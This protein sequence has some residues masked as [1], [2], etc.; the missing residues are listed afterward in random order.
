MEATRKR[1]GGPWATRQAFW[2]GPGRGEQRVS[3]KVLEEQTYGTCLVK[4]SY[5]GGLISPLSL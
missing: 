4:V 1:G 3:L 5:V 2:E